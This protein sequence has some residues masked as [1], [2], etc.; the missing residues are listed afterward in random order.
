[1]RLVLYQPDIPPNAG[2]LIRLGACL[3]VPVDIIEPCGFPFNDRSF[4]RAGLDYL[5]LAEVTRHS[6]WAA[7]AEFRRG[8][9][10]RLILMTTRAEQDHLSFAFAPADS[11]VLGSETAGVPDAV[12]E[13]VDARLR[14]PMV[15]GRRSLNVAVA[16]AI[17]LAE[18]LRQTDRFPSAGVE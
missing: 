12:H 5:D 17:A 14:I 4:R 2:T 16:G 18:A 7:Y 11:V 1:M 9:S 10:G 13:G 3:G 15:A 8:R 6:S